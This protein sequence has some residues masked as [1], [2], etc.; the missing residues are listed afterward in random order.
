MSQRDDSNNVLSPEKISE[1]LRNE[2][3]SI[4]D[5]NE[6]SIKIC[7]TK[8]VALQ[9]TL[10]RLSSLLCDEIQRVSDRVSKDV[11]IMDSVRRKYEDNIVQLQGQVNL[12]VGGAKFTTSTETLLAVPDSFSLACFAGSF[13]I[14]FFLFFMK[15]HGI[16]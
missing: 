3:F 7:A 9:G 10:I 5:L 16:H 12:N 6:S 2:Y 8:I 14:S 11:V 15:Y 1:M 4:E 13:C